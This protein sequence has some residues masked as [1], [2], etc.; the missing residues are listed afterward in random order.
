M[1]QLEELSLL[2]MTQTELGR[3]QVELILNSAKKLKKFETL[4][5]ASMA[6]VDPEIMAEK[7]NQ[8]KEFTILSEDFNSRSL[9]RVLSQA[10]KKTSLKKIHW[11]EDI[12]TKG[13]VVILDLISEAK[14][15]IS[16]VRICILLLC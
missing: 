16:G 9:E 8:L 5:V 10:V 13:E 1:A 6:E 12:K 15:V 11:E 7:V 14:K 3:G 4:R 2:S